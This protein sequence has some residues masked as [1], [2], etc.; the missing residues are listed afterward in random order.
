MNNKLL[1]FLSLFTLTSTLLAACGGKKPEAV[2]ITL[3][4]GFSRG[5]DSVSRETFRE[6]EQEYNSSHQDIKIE[7]IH[8]TP[9]EHASKFSTL[10]TGETP[11]DIAFPIDIQGVTEYYDEWLDVAS[12][13]Q[14][15]EYDAS[16]FYEPSLQLLKYS[17]KTVGFPLGLYPSVVFFNV[18]LFDIAG[19]EYPPQYYGDVNWSYDEL[20]NVAAQLTLD[21]NRNDA[22]SIN[23]DTAIIDQWGWGGWCGSFRTIP[24][25][26]GDT[27][28]GISSD[29][30]EA[31][32]NTGGYQEGMQFLYNTIHTWFIRPS[33]AVEE[34]TFSGLDFTFESGR[35]AMFECFSWAEYAF[36][37]FTLAGNWNIAAIPAGPHGDIVSPVDAAA[38]AIS[39]H[40]KNPDQAWSVIS[41]IM[42][43]EIQKRV[44]EALSCIP[45]RKSLAEDWVT[46]MTSRYPNVDFKVFIDSIAY[47]DASPNSNAWIPNHQKV[48]NA[49]ENTRNRI[50]DGPDDNVQKLM[51]RLNTQI[52]NELDEYWKT[53]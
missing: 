40:S 30:R 37:H 28:L 23:F 18:D 25:K 34:S 8:S 42:K 36:P 44:C 9:E 47:M 29:L 22:N 26:F 45:S 35:V 51:N 1:G 17:D 12:Y 41:W 11:P 33:K 6:I 52:Q 24:G 14:R 32:M 31:Q 4:T 48:W 2:N 7:F 3:F 19:I 21:E 53:H 5:I 38:F 20:M 43:P 46:R 10:L 50:L 15:A 13:I 49:L 27:S 16:N 39:K